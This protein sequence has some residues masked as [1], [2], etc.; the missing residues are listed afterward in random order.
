M[1]YVT[2]KNMTIQ[3]KSASL[4]LEMSHRP[5]E[6]PHPSAI[7]PD[8]S[9]FFAGSAQIGSTT[10]F[11]L[12]RYLPSNQVSVYTANSVRSAMP[13]D[14]PAGTYHLLAA[15]QDSAGNIT[16][17][18]ADGSTITLANAMGLAGRRDGRWTGDKPSLARHQKKECLP[19]PFARHQARTDSPLTRCA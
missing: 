5:R 18:G 2:R 11:A 7:Q 4:C 19:E 12:A 9:T 10:Q 1:T 15:V 13:K 6:L 14:A 8:R 17:A 16:A 3:F